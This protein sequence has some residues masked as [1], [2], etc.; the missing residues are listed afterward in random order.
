MSVD[1][2]RILSPGGLL[3]LGEPSSSLLPKESPPT[4][5]YLDGQ[6]DRRP[7]TWTANKTDDLVP[8]RPT[9]TLE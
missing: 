9:R 1:H 2:G 6:Q 5:L 8:G 3:Y 7:C 4:T